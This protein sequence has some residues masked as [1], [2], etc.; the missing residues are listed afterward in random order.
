MF[1][2]I[3]EISILTIFRTSCSQAVPPSSGD[4]SI[5]LQLSWQSSEL[6]A[7]KLFLLIRKILILITF[8]SLPNQKFQSWRTLELAAHCYA[9]V[10]SWQLAYLAAP[11]LFL[12]STSFRLTIFR[13]R[14]SRGCSFLLSIDLYHLK[15]IVSRDGGWGKA[16]E[17]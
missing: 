1:L 9:R 10:Q 11:W 8:R 2:P 5:S 17:W 4:Y 7:R 14:R 12:L 15:G 16:L 6:T 13:L 3:W